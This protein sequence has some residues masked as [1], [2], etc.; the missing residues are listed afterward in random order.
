MLKLRAILSR[1]ISLARRGYADVLDFCFPVPMATIHEEAAD[2][3]PEP[4]AFPVLPP[5]SSATPGATSTSTGPTDRI[6]SR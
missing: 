5:A 3:E 6:I 1:L 4:G 2:G